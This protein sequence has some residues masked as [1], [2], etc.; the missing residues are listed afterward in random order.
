MRK[1]SGLEF[2]E[3]IFIW[4]I[5]QKRMNIK[6][7]DQHIWL[8]LN[9]IL[10]KKEA[11]IAYNSISSIA[12]ILPRISFRSLV[13][14]NVSI[15]EEKI[16]SIYFLINTTDKKNIRHKIVNSLNIDNININNILNEIS[17]YKKQI[18]K[19]N[20]CYIKSKFKEKNKKL[21]DLSSFQVLFIKSLRIWHKALQE[22]LDMFGM[23]YK[24]HLE[25]D[26]A[27]ITISMHSLIE[28]IYL[29]KNKILDINCINCKKI[30]LDEIKIIE[31]IERSL[32]NEWYD[33]KNIMIDYLK[34][35][36]IENV[37]VTLKQLAANLLLSEIII[38]PNNNLILNFNLIRKNS[39][40]KNISIE[41]NKYIN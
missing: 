33:C 18:N 37:L 30:T 20:N 21:N 5:R 9:K 25:R 10:A 23:L 27:F 16:L 13:T 41:K 11:I 1:I 31:L 8:C 28:K 6:Q 22:D 15:D 7:R 12:N 34:I 36:S 29:E 2:E 3:Q 32:N 19:S 35:K 14:S 26:C 40:S 38:K 17:T 24:F 39:I 4:L